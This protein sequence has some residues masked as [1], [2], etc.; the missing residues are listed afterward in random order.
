MKIRMT[1]SISGSDF[2][3]APGDEDE[4]KIFT[5]KERKRLVA[6]GQA[7]AVPKAKTETT[8]RREPRKETRG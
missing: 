7:V 6:N 5:L 8:V 2:A 1:T 3:L 4:G